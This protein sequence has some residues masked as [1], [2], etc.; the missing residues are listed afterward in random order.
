MAE[1][2][3]D[4][5]EAVYKYLSNEFPELPRDHA[6]DKERMA[7]KFSVEKSDKI[8]IVKFTKLCWDKC[9]ANTLIEHLE[10]LDVA[11]ALRKNPEKNVIVNE[12][13]NLNFE[14]K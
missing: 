1:N 12:S 13:I 11:N 14:P 4:K 3:Q 2:D 8:Y 5:I 10:N 6:Y 9:D 7:P